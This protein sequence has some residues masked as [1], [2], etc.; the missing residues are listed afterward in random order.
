MTGLEIDPVLTPV[1]LESWGQLHFIFLCIGMM[2]TKLYLSRLKS[3]IL[4]AKS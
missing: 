2:Q 1:E 3:V 4:A